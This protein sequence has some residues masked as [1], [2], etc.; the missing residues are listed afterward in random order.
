MDLWVFCATSAATVLETTGVWAEVSPVVAVAHSRALLPL[1]PTRSSKGLLAVV[2]LS[3]L[4]LVGCVPGWPWPIV[5]GP[6]YCTLCPELRLYH[7][8]RVLFWRGLSQ[9]PEILVILHPVVSLPGHAH[10]QPPV[11]YKGPRFFV[12]QISIGVDVKG[13]GP[14]IAVGDPSFRRLLVDCQLLLFFPIR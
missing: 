4:L 6:W 3:T 8:P 13:S 5:C 2:V 9:A 11:L 1:S 12:S 10:Y 7:V 14:C